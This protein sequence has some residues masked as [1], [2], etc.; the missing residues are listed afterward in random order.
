MR[1]VCGERILVARNHDWPFGGG[2]VITHPKGLV[3]TALS[4]LQP[5]TWTSTHGSV[6]F[7]Q[8]GRGI[9]FAG[10]NEAGLTVDL[11]QLRQT[12]F[13]PPNLL[14]GQKS[15]NAIQWVQY[16]LDTAA[17]VVDVLASLQNVVPLPL[18][19]SIERVHYFVT[20]A[21]G[22]AAIIEFLD[23]QLVTQHRNGSGDALKTSVCA[24]SNAT[25]SDSQA[26]TLEQAQSDYKLMR[27][28]LAVEATHGWDGNSDPVDYAL[29]CL[30]RVRQPPFTQW[31]LVYDPS[32]KRITF[33]TVESPSTRW[34]D[35]DELQLS[36]GDQVR[37]IDVQDNR[38]GNLQSHLTP[39][40]RLRND[41]LIDDAFANL[42]EFGRSP[43]ILLR[44]AKTIVSRYPESLQLAP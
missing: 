43:S 14:A 35:L 42:S 24:L 3:K 20:D 44:A 5:I 28:R 6:S 39:Y 37:L 27:Y 34:I 1:L 7:T 15:V 11:L 31:N 26:A 36:A 17:S 4:P 8:Y 2:L 30:Q 29:S 10:M 38:T 21:S 22:D 33:R 23:G 12:Q 25:W 9:P 19:P 32:E 13:A 40:S 41:K 18:F 16:Q